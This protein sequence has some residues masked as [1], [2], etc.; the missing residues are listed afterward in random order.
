[1][2]NGK[3]RN[4]R[5]QLTGKEGLPEKETMIR[6]RKRGR[7]EDKRLGMSKGKKGR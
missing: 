4:E 5:K 6:R 7:E 1:M 2:R 3:K